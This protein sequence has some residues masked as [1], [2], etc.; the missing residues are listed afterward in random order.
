MDVTESVWLPVLYFLGLFVNFLGF[1]LDDC[2][3]PPKITSG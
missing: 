1:L 3:Y 2:I